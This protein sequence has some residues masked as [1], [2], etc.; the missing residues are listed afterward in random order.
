M[1]ILVICGLIL[2]VIFSSLFLLQ[3]VL[4]ET[5]EKILE[6]LTD[7]ERIRSHYAKVLQMRDRIAKLAHEVNYI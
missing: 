1:H 4:K 5:A 3:E 6:S 2:D 7:N